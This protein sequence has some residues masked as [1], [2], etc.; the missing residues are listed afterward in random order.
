V[1]TNKKSA[2]VLMTSPLAGFIPTRLSTTLMYIVYRDL[3]PFVNQNRLEEI[4]VEWPLLEE[5]LVK[6]VLSGRELSEYDMQ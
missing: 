1:V 3:T 2:E 4:L 6:M 5:E